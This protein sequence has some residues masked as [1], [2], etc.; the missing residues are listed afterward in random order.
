MLRFGTCYD[1]DANSALPCKFFY[2]VGDPRFP[3]DWAQGVALFHNP[4]ATNQLPRDLF[5]DVMHARS[6]A[7]VLKSVIPLFFPLNSVTHV[8]QPGGTRQASRSSRRQ[9]TVEL[10]KGR[11]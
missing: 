6:D 1:H 3:E 9:S 10:P 2:E 7:G 5:P 11:R 4:S 8:L